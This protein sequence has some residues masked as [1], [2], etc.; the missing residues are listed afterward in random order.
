MPARSPPP[1]ALNPEDLAAIDA[2]LERAW[3]EQGLA[4]NT[5]ASYRH[6]LEG[7]ARWAGEAVAVALGSFVLDRLFRFGLPIRL[8]IVFLGLGFLLVELCRWVIG[9]MLLEL[10]VVGL[11]AAIDRVGGPLPAR[12]A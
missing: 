3:S 8:S 10:N 7:L 9:P 11:A 2:F 12:P 4:Q 5:L 1:S 6:D